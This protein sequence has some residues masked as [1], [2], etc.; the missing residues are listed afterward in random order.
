M[1]RI[2][3]QE[4]VVIQPSPEGLLEFEAEKLSKLTIRVEEVCSQICPVPT[5]PQLVEQFPGLGDEPG[6]VRKKSTNVGSIYD[7]GTCSF[8]NGQWGLAE[9]GI[10]AESAHFMSFQRTLENGSNQEQSV[11]VLSLG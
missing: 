1:Q 9:Q 6:I 5:F 7:H 11:T 8:I 2:G 3:L 10:R 4:I